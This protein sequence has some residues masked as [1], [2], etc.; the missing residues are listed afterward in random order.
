M[1]EFIGG[2][3]LGS[4]LGV[5]ADRIWE[6]FEKRLRL[7]LTIGNF[8]NHK[9]EEGLSYLVRNDGP[10]EIQR[11]A[12][13]LQ[14]PYRGTMSAFYSEQSGPLRPGETREYQCP[15][16]KHGVPAP[17]L[18]YWITHEKD[19]IVTEPT[20]DQF[21]LLVNTENSESAHFESKKMGIA[22]AKAWH[23]SF[24][25]NK[26][27]ILTAADQRALSSPPGFGIKKWIKLRR[28]KY[29]GERMTQHDRHDTRN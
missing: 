11:I 26:P 16:F 6:R 23:R 19:A 10:S 8:H 3:F 5:V 1:V 17:F 7:E 29:E 25:L 28:K 24:E 4:V 12:I 13:G 9:G 27:A 18:K 21:K 15:L 22:L 14:H 20:F 2:L